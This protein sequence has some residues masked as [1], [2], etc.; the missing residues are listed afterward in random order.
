M[1]ILLMF[2]EYFI[3]I[4]STCYQHVINILLIFY[5]YFISGYPV[6]QY[7][8]VYHGHGVVCNVTSQELVISYLKPYS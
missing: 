2:Y 7:S 4:L 1:N 8:E 5:H 3:N 6:C